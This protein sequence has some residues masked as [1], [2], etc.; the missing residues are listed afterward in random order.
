MKLKPLKFDRPVFFFRNTPDAAERGPFAL[1]GLRD[2]AEFGHIT[3]EILIRK[4]SDADFHCLRDDPDLLR[5]IFPERRHL[6]LGHYEAETKTEDRFRPVDFADARRCFPGKEESAPG[7]SAGVAPRSRAAASGIRLNPQRGNYEAVSET[8]AETSASAFDPRRALE[9]ITEK[10]RSE[11][12]EPENKE[13]RAGT[14]LVFG[15]RLVGALLFAGYGLSIFLL[16][17]LGTGPAVVILD[18]LIGVLLIVLG[19]VFVLPEVLRIVTA[20]FCGM[21]D[22]L[23]FGS[24]REDRRADYGAAELYLA[25]GDTEAALREYRNIV[26]RFPKEIPA[27][28]QGIRLCRKLGRKGESKELYNRALRR[29]SSAQDRNLFIG[30]VRRLGSE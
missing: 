5:E 15:A 14:W 30:A 11:F 8:K 23:L 12:T 16:V 10:S 1:D 29:I 24:A 18:F 2:L 7:N 13:T 25:N 9:E 17:D 3:P 4:D 26:S 27:Y 21:V 28:L 6:H 22:V 20:P 19:L